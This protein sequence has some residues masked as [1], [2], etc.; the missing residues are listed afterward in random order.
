MTYSEQRGT[1]Q[2]R[3]CSAVDT[4][5]LPPGYVISGHIHAGISFSGGAQQRLRLPCFVMG[6]RRA[7]FPAF[8]TFTG[9]RRFTP[10]PGDKIF[11]VAGESIVEAGSAGSIHGS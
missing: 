5:N 2:K 1:F 11:V 7:I 3:Q 6:E 4:D 10:A 9:N 8:G